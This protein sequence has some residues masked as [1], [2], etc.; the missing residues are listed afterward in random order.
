MSKPG[1]EDSSERQE[2]EHILWG[3]PC[4]KREGKNKAATHHSERLQSLVVMEKAISL[5]RVCPY[6][7]SL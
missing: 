3:E 2:Y 4:L 1:G 5:D 7:V 6:S